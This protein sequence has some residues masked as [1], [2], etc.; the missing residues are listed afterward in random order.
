MYLCFKNFITQFCVTLKKKYVKN[1]LQI[2]P[3][4]PEGT[5]WLFQVF[6]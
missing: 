5:I 2:A 1:S 3:L 4:V 6:E